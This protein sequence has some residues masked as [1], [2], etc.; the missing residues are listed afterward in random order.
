MRRRPPLH[1]DH[2][3]F[4]LALDAGLRGGE[5]HVWSPYSVGEALGL[6]ATG[7]RGATRTE[8]EGL[9]GRDLGAHLRTLEEA[10][11]PDGAGGPELETATSLWAREDL[12][13]DPGFE[14]AVAARRS[15]SVRTADF[16]GD[17]EGVRKAANAEVAEATHGL[18]TDLLRAGDITTATQA[19]LLNALWVRLLWTDPFDPAQTSPH[20]F[21]SPGGAVQAAMMHRQGRMPYAEAGGWAMVTLGSEHDLALD[22]LLPPEEGGAPLPALTAEALSGL[23]SARS[24]EEV[25]LSLPRFEISS[26]AMLSGV[27]A[28]TGVRTLFTSDADL[29]GIADRRLLVDE[30][31]H[32]ALLRVDERGAEGAAATAVV[33]RTMSLVPPKPPRVFTA[34]R[35]FAFVLR[36]RSAALFL[37][38]ITAPE[39]PGPAE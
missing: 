10:V 7:A 18:I 35:P 27:L 24:T 9:L 11:A 22:V 12:R 3:A 19:L 34:D 5:S 20:P 17:P 39:D 13:V 15:A 26:R 1:P 2:L 23:Y 30:V 29:S 16:A 14:R 6:V 33:M 38:A 4:A 32:Q 28:A 37:G 36:R 25:R 8:L 31:V 21:R